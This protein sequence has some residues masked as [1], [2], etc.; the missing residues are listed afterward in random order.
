MIEIPEILKQKGINFVLVEK[1]GKKPFQKGWQ[2]KIIPFDSLELKDHIESDGNYGIIG[3]GEKN[4]ILVDFDDEHIQKLALPMLPETFTVKTGSGMLHLYYFTNGDGSFKGFDEELNTLFDVQS[5]GK[6]VV[7]PGSQHPNGRYYEVVTN[8]PIS[9]IDYSELKAALMTFDRKPKKKEMN[10]KAVGNKIEYV[11]ISGNDFLEKVK[12][13]ISMEQTLRWAKVDTSSNPTKC[14]FHDSKGG[15]CLGFNNTTAHCFHCIHPNQDI[16]TLDGLKNISDVKVGD[17]TINANGERVPIVHITKH[18]FSGNMLSIYVNGNNQPL[19]VTDNHR[20]Y[21][22]K[23]IKLPCG[24]IKNKSYGE[25]NLNLVGKSSAKNLNNLDALFFPIPN[26]IR[27]KKFISVDKFTKEYR[28]GPRRNKISKLP[29]TKEFLWVIGMYLAEG[30]SFR[31]GIKFSLH[32]KET[33]YAKRILSVFKKEL[34]LNGST[35]N[36]KTPTGE[37]LLVHICNTDLSDIFPKLFGSGS[38]NKKIPRELL[39]LPKDKCKSL[40]R[41]VLDGDGSSRDDTLGQTSKQLMMDGYELALKVGYYPSMGLIKTPKGKKQVYTMYPAIKGYGKYKTNNHLISP[42]NKIETRKYNG[43]VYDITVDSNHHSLL[44]PQGIIGNCEGSWNIF[45][46]VQ[47]HKKCDFKESLDILAGLAG[48]KDELIDAKKDYAETMRKLEAD[49][50]QKKL[51]ADIKNREA[52]REG[53][54]NVPGDTG[55]VKTITGEIRNPY[56]DNMK[57]RMNRLKIIQ[58]T[59]LGPK[60]DEKEDR[61]KVKEDIDGITKD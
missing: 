26:I 20:M 34:N 27:D 33:N 59:T 54:I 30:N 24:K 48:M 13:K 36:Q 7:G 19:Q 35:F 10:L 38:H 39:D 29:L 1:K 2:K 15:Q 57:R 22:Y 8:V 40:L 23:N 41:G 46:F 17:V 43:E 55:D 49:E 21:Y 60:P 6:Q 44:T 56:V 3:G 53:K 45:S 18:K 31:G 51:D 4:L 32:K 14:P 16:F 5:A 28:L 61:I 47:E 50:L 25:K 42:I 11:K 12:E 9:F 52:R 37:A 58:G